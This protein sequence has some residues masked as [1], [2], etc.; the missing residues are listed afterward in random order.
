MSVIVIG[1]VLCA[2][3]LFFIFVM[4]YVICKPGIIREVIREPLL[5][6]DDL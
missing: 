6:I 4:Y 5:I 3:I 1:I 2:P